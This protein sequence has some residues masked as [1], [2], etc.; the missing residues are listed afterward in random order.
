LLILFAE[1]PVLAME[2]VVMS[3]KEA[4]PGL[5]EPGTPVP[6]NISD[7]LTSMA[8]AAKALPTDNSKSTH[9]SKNYGKE[10]FEATTL[11][12]IGS[13]STKPWWRIV[14]C[15]ER[16]HKQENQ[17]LCQGLRADAANRG[18]F[19]VCLKKAAQFVLW[20]R[21]MRRPPFVLVTDWREAQPCTKCLATL[22]EVSRPFQIVVLC[23]SQRQLG[24]ASAWAQSLPSESGPVTVCSR[25]DIP[26]SLLDGILRQ[27]F[28][29]SENPGE[30]ITKPPSASTGALMKRWSSE[31]VLGTASPK[32]WQHEVACSTPTESDAAGHEGMSETSEDDGWNRTISPQPSMSTTHAHEAGLHPNRFAPVKLM[33]ESGGAL[34]IR[35]CPEGFRSSQSSTMC[36]SS[37]RV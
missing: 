8:D 11:T 14:W 15:H 22:P 33:R 21:R 37:N 2:P 13:V 24:K 34:C 1:H 25:T 26:A 5:P 32:A 27:H 36:S 30:S 31:V 7:C 10:A 16:C 19:L 23:E 28:G 20:V 29:T 35:K 6:L 9:P 3:I 17:A 12:N 18:S 4:P